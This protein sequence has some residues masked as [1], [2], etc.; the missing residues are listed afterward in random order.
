MKYAV[1]SRESGDKYRY[2]DSLD[3]AKRQATEYQYE[4]LE[5]GIFNT[6]AYKIYQVV[7]GR[8]EEVR[9]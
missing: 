2:F 7:Q 6:E 8:F 1:L 5:A 9:V 4:D 3:D